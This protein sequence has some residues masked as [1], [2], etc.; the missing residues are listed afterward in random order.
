MSLAMAQGHDVQATRDMS[1]SEFGGELEPAMCGVVLVPAAAEHLHAASVASA[2]LTAVRDEQS[3]PGLKLTVA[4]LDHHLDTTC[5]QVIVAPS[6]AK[7]L[8]DATARITT[9]HPQLPQP[10]LLVVRD[11]PLPPPPI[12][13]HRARA[14]AERVEAGLEIPYLHRLRLVDEPGQALHGKGRDLK[15]ARGALLKVLARLYGGAFLAAGGASAAPVPD[16]EL[17]S[18]ADPT[19][20]IHP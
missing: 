14:L 2:L 15:R 16:L 4:G 8:A 5:L 13:V 9:W 10:V 11:A 6:T 17:G 20:A 19:P 18:A 12:V 7:G 3:T 1:A